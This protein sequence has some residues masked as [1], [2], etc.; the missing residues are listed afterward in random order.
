MIRVKLGAE[1]ELI[2]RQEVKVTRVP[3][4]IRAREVMKQSDI[5]MEHVVQ[6]GF[7]E[8]VFHRVPV[9]R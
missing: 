7:G 4:G 6:E 1:L 9:E 8:K 2:I 3:A 5:G